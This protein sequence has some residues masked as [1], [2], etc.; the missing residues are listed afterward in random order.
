MDKKLLGSY[1]IDG[2]EQFSM[3]IMLFLLCL[4][5]TVSSREPKNCLGQ[6]GPS[7]SLV[8]IGQIRGELL[9]QIWKLSRMQ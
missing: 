8:T 9:W 4:G 3:I 2:Q 7:C 5:R 6:G 1:L